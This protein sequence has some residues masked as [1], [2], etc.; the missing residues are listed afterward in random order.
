MFGGGNTVA[1]DK[2][3]RI[4]TSASGEKIGNSTIKCCAMLD[5]G[6]EDDEITP[7]TTQTQMIG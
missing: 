6:L 2:K 1:D 4:A 5:I 7:V 3:V